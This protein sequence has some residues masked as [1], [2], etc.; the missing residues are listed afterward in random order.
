VQL[1]DINIVPGSSQT[2]GIKWPLLVTRDTGIHADLHTYP[3]RCRTMDSDMV[4]SGSKGWYII[5]VSGGSAGHSHKAV[6]HTLSSL[7]TYQHALSLPSLYHI[8]L[9]LVSPRPW[10]S[11]ALLVLPGSGWGSWKLFSTVV[12]YNSFFYPKH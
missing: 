9:I 2:R 10:V 4:F 11:S 1:L 3:T 8:L 7:C 6:L 5:M 12:K